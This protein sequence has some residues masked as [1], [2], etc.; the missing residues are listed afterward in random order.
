MCK[1]T[2]CLSRNHIR[3]SGTQGNKTKTKRIHGKKIMDPFV[4][5]GLTPTDPVARQ[6]VLRHPGTG[7]P[8][9]TKH[10]FVTEQYRDTL[11]YV[12]NRPDYLLWQAAGENMS[13]ARLRHSLLCAMVAGPC[14]NEPE[15]RPREE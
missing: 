4:R 7:T 9:T 3:E 11:H 6:L 8:E 10:E 15:R 5:P 2:S 12:A 14:G 1:C 13:S